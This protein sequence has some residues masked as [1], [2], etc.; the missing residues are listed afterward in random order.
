LETDPDPDYANYQEIQN[1]QH[2]TGLESCYANFEEIQR[3][4]C[5]QQ[6]LVQQTDAVSI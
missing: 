2:G 3:T 5:V 1:L 6:A 4:I